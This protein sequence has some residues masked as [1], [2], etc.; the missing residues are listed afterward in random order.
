MHYSY[1]VDTV[2]IKTIEEKGN[3]G[4]FHIEG[5]YTGYG[6]TL[7]NALR[8]VLLPSL[9]GAAISQVRINGVKHEFSTI[10]GMQE[11]VVALTLSLKQ[12][13]FHFHADEPQTLSLRVKGVSTVTAG[14]IAST[15]LAEGINTDRPIAPL[16][17]KKA[18]LDKKIVVAQGR[19]Y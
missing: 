1:L 10:P 4:V 9:P 15:S 11:D 3:K 19:G 16:T 18:E 13:R 14:D 7:G 8:R 2:G 6:I 5:L 12:V 17:T